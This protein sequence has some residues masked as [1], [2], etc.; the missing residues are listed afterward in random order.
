MGRKL[1]RAPHGGQSGAL[2]ATFGYV[3]GRAPPDGAF[4]AG[5]AVEL[6]R[7]RTFLGMER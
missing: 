1:P 3:D 7:M 2:A 4:R 5:L 6:D